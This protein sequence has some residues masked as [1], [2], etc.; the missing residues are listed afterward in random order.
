MFTYKN[1]NQKEIYIKSENLTKFRITGICLAS[2]EGKIR[3]N[4]FKKK[5]LRI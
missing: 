2:R 1:R 4:Q 3:N 5:E